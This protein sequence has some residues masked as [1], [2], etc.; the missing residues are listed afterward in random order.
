MSNNTKN[1]LVPSLRF[2]EFTHAWEQ[3]VMGNIYAFGKTGGTPLTTNKKFYNGK[4]PFLT[5][6][7]IT[8]S[9]KYLTET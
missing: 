3:D 7:D 1:N 8:N 2:K 6:K 9:E 5:I 4:I